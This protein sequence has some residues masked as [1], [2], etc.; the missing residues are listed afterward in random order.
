[1]VIF[2]D[3]PEFFVEFHFAFVNCLPERFIQLRNIIL[4]SFP[5]HISLPNPFNKTLKVDLLD[6]IKE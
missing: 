4:S 6:E 1:M 3:F 2:K 5:S